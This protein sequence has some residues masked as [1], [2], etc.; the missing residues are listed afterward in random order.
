MN[1]SSIGVLVMAGGTGGH[2][3][4]ALSVAKELKQ[5]GYRVRWLGSVG[6]MEQELVTREGLDIDLLPVSG[7]RGKGKLAVVKAPWVI[8]R[9]VLKALTLIRQHEISLVLGFGGFASGPGGLAAAI[10]GRKLLIH[11]QNAIA[12]LTNRLLAK[13]ADVVCEAFPG[14]F[15]PN[16]KVFTTGNPLR[17]SLL[18]LSDQNLKRCAYQDRNSSLKLL[19]VGGSRGAVVFNQE[20]PELLAACDDHKLLEIT[21]QC[22]KGNAA[23]VEQN[24]LNAGL[25]NV[26]VHEFMHDMDQAYRWADIIICRAGALTVSEVA[27]MGLP[28][29]FVPYPFAVD[30]HQTKNAEI[31]ANQGAAVIIQQKNM[32]SIVS[33]LNQWLNN[34]EQLKIMSEKAMQLA[35]IDAK[36]K[37][38]AHCQ[39]LVGNA[40]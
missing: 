7:I 18:N 16:A 35:I 22:G 12:G 26:V 21:H 5:R 17:Q 36:E 24:Y 31:L 34:R 10:S 6:G 19:V 40:A 20:L 14:A 30:D 27:A 32:T 4:P 23:L 37:I 39:Q 3:Y 11:E 1:T 25:S 13:R 9:C 8:I 38:V 28:A 2:I 33:V 15:K 29:I